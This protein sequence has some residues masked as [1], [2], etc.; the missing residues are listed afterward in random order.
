MLK[1]LRGGYPMFYLMCM[2]HCIYFFNQVYL[3]FNNRPRTEN[4]LERA[5]FLPQQNYRGHARLLDD[6]KA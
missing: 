2:F 6:P 5:I 4:T 3:Y 1:T